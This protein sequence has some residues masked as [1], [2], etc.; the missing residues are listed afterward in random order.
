VRYVLEGSVRRSGNRVRVNAQLIDAVTD[1]HLWADRCDCTMADLLG[2]QDDITRWIANALGVEMIAAEAARP[3]EHPDALD[4]ILRGRAAFSTQP[5]R[6]SYPQ[7]I[8]LFECA[9]ALDPRSAEAQSWLASALVDR[10]LFGIHDSAAADIVRAE[11]LIEQALEA[12]PGLPQAHFA[13]AQLLRAQ[14]RPE[15][16]IPEY[17]MVIA[18]NRNW[19]FAIFGLA[20]CKLLTGSIEEAIPLS[21][22]AVRLSPRDPYI[23]HWYSR[24]GKVHLLQSRTDEAILW[25]EK[26]RGANPRFAFVHIYLAAAY[27]LKGLTERAATELAEAR[28]LASDDR[29]RSIARLRTRGYRGVPKIR[30]LEETTYFAGLRKAGMPEE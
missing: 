1:A 7:A 9:L 11:G 24:G 12:S 27:G 16:A 18:S 15:E 3:T 23:A 22:Q 19:V 17:Q 5:S 10:V 6:D 13:K 29:Y 4:Y 25:F 21:E 28:R 20:E 26:A 30:A 2:L 8:G 14:G